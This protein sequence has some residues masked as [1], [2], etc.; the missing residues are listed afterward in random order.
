MNRRDLCKN[1]VFSKAV[2]ECY[3]KWL[4]MKG[5][6]KSTIESY[7]TSVRLYFDAGYGWS[8]SEACMWKEEEMQRVKPASVNIRVHALNSFAEFT[9]SKWKL[10]PVRI[11][12]QQFVEHQLTMSQYEKL[13]KCLLDDGNIRWWA[14]IKVL[15]CTGVRIS[16]FLQIKRED[17]KIGYV[18]VC[19]KGDKYRRIWFSSSLRQEVLSIYK[20][21][22]YFLPYNTGVIRKKLHSFAKKYGLKKEPMHPHEFRAFYARNIYEKCKD[23]KF[24]QDLLGHADIKTTVRYL[25]KTSKG[26]S[27]RIS[28]IVTW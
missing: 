10:K 8:F 18:D 4:R 12:A 23:L 5:L 13:L 26:I 24:L 15:A 27:R 20:E 21:D 28:K 9:G 16:E 2:I 17:L 14:S 11:Q 7:T 22:G 1:F 25:R 6:S 3:A 19:G